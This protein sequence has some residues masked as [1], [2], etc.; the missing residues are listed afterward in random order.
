MARQLFGG[1]QFLTTI[2]MSEYQEEVSA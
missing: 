1:E 2:N